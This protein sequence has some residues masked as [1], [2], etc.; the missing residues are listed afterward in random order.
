MTALTDLPATTLSAR[1]AAG[2]LSSVEVAIAF[3]D[4]IG[5]VNPGLNALVSLRP[6]EEVLAEAAEADRAP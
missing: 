2:G 6:R 3:L 5:A 1:M 4:R